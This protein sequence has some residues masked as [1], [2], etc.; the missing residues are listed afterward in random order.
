MLSESY[1]R[2]E[3]LMLQSMAILTVELFELFLH[4]EEIVFEGY[5]FDIVYVL[6]YYEGRI[7]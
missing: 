4:R 6:T 2:F 3:E 7:F 1:L 5:T